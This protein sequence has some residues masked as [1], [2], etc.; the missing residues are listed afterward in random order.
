MKHGFYADAG[1][2]T[3]KARRTITDP[4]IM[5]PIDARQLFY[6]V[7]KGYL[8][9][10]NIRKDI[11][12][13]KN[14]ADPA[15]RVLTI[16]QTL[17]FLSNCIGRWAQGL[18]V[19]TM[20]LTT[21]GFALCTFATYYF[22][23]HKPSDVETAIDLE[24]NITIDEL[25][26]KAGLSEHHKHFLTPLFFISR[27]EWF[28]S[29]EY[30][31]W[32]SWFRI[33]GFPSGPKTRPIKRIRNDNFPEISS[34]A[35]AI[36]FFFSGVF[37]GLNFVAWNYH[38]PTHA[39]LML[40]RVASIGTPGSLAAYWVHSKIRLTLLPALR[41][42]QRKDSRPKE[43]P[44]WFGSKAL[45]QTLKRSAG[46]L[47]NLDIDQDPSFAVE[48]TSIIPSTLLAVF[49]LSARLYI[50]VEEFVGLR[51]MPPSAYQSVEWTNYLLHL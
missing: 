4:Y 19:T 12:S 41:K 18:A 8:P 10:P 50:L 22:W 36:F 27:N 45:V 46:K 47:R 35:M 3:L 29:K 44:L 49:Y 23:A 17:Y 13:D 14:K 7:D 31:Y 5:F 11:I 2:F 38:F 6:L 28:W 32:L 21:L 48:L 37:T 9:Y 24:N 15:V 42:Y 33:A 43:L 51:A 20:E 16:A 40:W 1:G 30:N 26:A 34:T 25:H 39:E